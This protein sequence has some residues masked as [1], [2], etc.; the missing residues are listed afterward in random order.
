VC[1]ALSYFE[2]NGTSFIDL[3][4]NDKIPGSCVE[5]KGEDKEK[6][7]PKKDITAPAA[8]EVKS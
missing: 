7:Q 3:P 6:D 8:T 4:K 2:N 1:K 5:L